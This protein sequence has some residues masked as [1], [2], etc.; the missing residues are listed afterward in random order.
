LFLQSHI[1]RFITKIKEERV[2][3]FITLGEGLTPILAEYGTMSRK[4]PRYQIEKINL[5]GD[6]TGAVLNVRTLKW[7]MCS[8]LSCSFPTEIAAKIYA[9][10]NGLIE[11]K[12]VEITEHIWEDHDENGKK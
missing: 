2:L 7:N 1:L 9:E 3:R 8:N 11:G 12:D 5:D 6:P 4:K 10:E